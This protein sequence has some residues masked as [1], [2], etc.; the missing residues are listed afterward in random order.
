[1]KQN[2]EQVIMKIREGHLDSQAASH[3]LVDGD[4]EEKAELA[5]FIGSHRVTELLT[6]L[7]EAFEM[8]LD[9]NIRA[10]YYWAICLIAPETM[11]ET[12]AQWILDEENEDARKSMV[13]SFFTYTDRYDIPLETIKV[14]QEVKQ[15]TFAPQKV[16]RPQ[17]EP[18]AVGRDILDLLTQFRPKIPVS[19]QRI[20]NLLRI[21]VEDLE[22]KL[23]NLEKQ[24]KL[25]GEYLRLEQ[26]F[27]KDT[28]RMKRIKCA[29]CGSLTDSYPCTECGGGKVCATCRLAIDI[30]EDILTCP[31]CGALSHANHLKEWI[32]I[33]G[34]CPACRKPLSSKDL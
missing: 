31:H 30:N 9:P 18:K 3:L 13:E 12:L 21:S 10:I 4:S 27:I 26:V 34:A 19:L 32:K 2:A 5:L 11:T 8:E 1:M 7:I 16:Q 14:V 29:S 17:P 33:K 20:A 6:P 24:G 15:K 25:P 22:T 28:K 23:E